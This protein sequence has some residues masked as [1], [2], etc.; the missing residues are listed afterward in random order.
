[1]D[2]Q[3]VAMAGAL[4]KVGTGL[5]ALPLADLPAIAFV[6]LRNE[7]EPRIDLQLSISSEPVSDLLA[8]GDVLPAPVAY[9]RDERDYIR[10]EIASL[11]DGVPLAVWTHL[12]GEHLAVARRLLGL[13]PDG[14]AHHLSVAVLR[15]LITDPGGDRR[16]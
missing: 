5:L 8:W 14:E 3:N 12:R 13:P 2:G 6:D 7:H 16:A 1:M 15:G 10:L 4:A 11:V 9:G